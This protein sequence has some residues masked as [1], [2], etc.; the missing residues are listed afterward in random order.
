MK[1]AMAAKH[2]T[3]KRILTCP[4]YILLL[5]EVTEVDCLKQIVA[6]LIDAADCG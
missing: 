6:R 5:Y 3:A 4:Q 2:A 1:S